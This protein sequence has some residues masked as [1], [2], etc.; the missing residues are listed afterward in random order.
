M[1][2][3]GVGTTAPDFCAGSIEPAR[4][5]HD[6]MSG[7]LKNPRNAVARSYFFD[8]IIPRL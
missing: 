6:R 8:A 4:I 2:L 7:M 3:S 1:S 5:K